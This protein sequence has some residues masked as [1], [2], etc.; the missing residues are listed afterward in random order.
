MVNQHDFISVT[1]EVNTI[2]IAFKDVADVSVAFV[3]G[4]AQ[5]NRKVAVFNRREEWE[6]V[7]EADGE[8]G[9]NNLEENVESIIALVQIEGN[10]LLDKASDDDFMN[11][12]L[13]LDH[14]SED[15]LGDII[16]T[17]D[18]GAQVLTLSGAAEDI[19]SGLEQVRTVPVVCSKS[20]LSDLRM[21][22]KVTKEVSC[23]EA[24]TR[25]D[26]IGSSGFGVSRSRMVKAIEGGEDTVNFKQ[27][28]SSSTALKVGDVIMAKNIGRLDVVEIG[29]TRKGR[30]RAKLMKT[31]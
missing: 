11:S 31:V 25:L 21:R 23:V 17:G 10:F 2:E 16:V 20:D 15:S 29:E 6:E 1:F 28:K 27:A 30:V 13:T 19:I 14:I 5:A 4:Y 18:R 24:S 7:L 26:A 12:I 3:G 8:G 9:R 22:P